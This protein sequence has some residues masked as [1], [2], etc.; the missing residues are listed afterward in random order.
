MRGKFAKETMSTRRNKAYKVREEHG[1]LGCLGSITVFL[2]MVCAALS[3]MIAGIGGESGFRPDGIDVTPITSSD[4]EPDDDSTGDEGIVEKDD[5]GDEGS[6]G[7]GEEEEEEEEEET[8]E[9]LSAELEGYYYYSQLN[10]ADRQKYEAMYQMASK[11][12][13][14]DFP[15]TNG[16]D[17]DHIY[18][19][20][21]GDHPEF[22][23]LKGLTTS[24]F[25]DSDVAKIEG[26]YLYAEDEIA[27][28]QS[29]VEAALAEALAG[30]PDGADDYTKAKHMYEYL[31]THVT[32]DHEGFDQNN[33]D[34]DSYRGQT[35]VDSL[36]NGNSV[37]AGYARAFQMAMQHMGIQ[38][39]Y[40]SGDLN[41]G[42]GSHAWCL[43]LLDGEYY[44]V[45]PTWGDPDSADEGADQLPEGFVIYAYLG[46]TTATMQASRDFD[47]WQPLPECTSTADNYYV[48]EGRMLDWADG[49]L[50]Q[51][52]WDEAVA[53]GDACFQ[54]GCSDASVYQE[55]V[56]GLANGTLLSTDA[57]YYYVSFDDVLTITVQPGA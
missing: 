28:Y 6:I 38:C 55:V 21:M 50:I 9:D 13:Q 35:V 3:L 51:Q 18:R 56:D 44:Y 36:V 46:D 15:S 5:E 10:E 11:R 25:S 29:Q 1:G 31:V 37:C 48:Y 7:E 45:D 30:I 8:A 43:A 26:S 54:F 17:I 20:V 41:D 16:E 52:W 34:P 4:E 40:V 42:R 27:S 47:A 19:C 53:N 39:A 2:L 49:A 57:S 12:D 14:V 23:Y 32:Y 22:F 24:T 33:F